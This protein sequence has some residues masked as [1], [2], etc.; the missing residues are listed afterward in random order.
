DGSLVRGFFANFVQQQ[1][2]VTGATVATSELAQSREI[3][4]VAR[5]FASLLPPHSRADSPLSTAAFHPDAVILQTTRREL[6]DLILWLSRRT[7]LDLWGPT[8]AYD[9]PFFVTAT[10]DYLNTAHA[11]WPLPDLTERASAVH[12][13]AR[14]FAQWLTLQPETNL[15]PD[16]PGVKSQIAIQLMSHPVGTERLG[17]PAEQFQGFAG[18]A[19]RLSTG[20]PENWSVRALS[21]EGNAGHVVPVN[22]NSSQLPSLE[23]EGIPAS[24]LQDSLTLAV[25]YR[26]FEFATT[27]TPANEGGIQLVVLPTT[28]RTTEIQVTQPFDDLG[29][30]AIVL[31]G[32]SSMKQPTVPKGGDAKID[33]ARR[34]LLEL[35]QQLSTLGAVDC[36]VRVYGHRVGYGELS[37]RV[38]VEPYYQGRGLDSTLDP[39][40]DIETV[41]TLGGFRATDQHILKQRLDHLVGWGQS[42]HFGAIVSALND[43][44]QPAGDGRQRAIVVVTDGGQFDISLE[45]IRI[46]DKVNLAELK[47]QLAEKPVP[48][49]FL[50]I[51]KQS[52]DDMAIIEQVAQLGG[53][54]VHTSEDVNGLVAELQSHD[55]QTYQV[56]GALGRDLDVVNPETASTA[57][58]G[59]SLILTPES[60]NAN[61]LVVAAGLAQEHLHIIGGERIELQISPDRANLFAPEYEREL[62]TPAPMRDGTGNVDVPTCFVHRPEAGTDSVTFPISWQRLDRR[63]VGWPAHVW[64]EVEPLGPA[65]AQASYIFYDIVPNKEAPI[66]L[67]RFHAPNWPTMATRALIRVWVS[68]APVEPDLQIAFSELEADTAGRI[69]ATVNRL[70]GI[71]LTI[72]SY[73]SSDGVAPYRIVVTEHHPN[74]GRTLPVKV[75]LETPSAV[76]ATRIT[77]HFDARHETITHTFDYPAYHAESVR[78]AGVLRILSRDSLAESG[79]TLGSGGHLVVPVPRPEPVISTRP[80][81][82]ENDASR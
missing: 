73:S 50:L 27:L 65:S 2:E 11:L 29:Q 71:E 21:S 28:D 40:A 23:L 16:A 39:T 52:P 82:N 76:V 68:P 24:D 72:V 69:Q 22:L 17:I 18:L 8:T 49:H 10:T 56:D 19:L 70:E 12:S 42:P 5:E 3:E 47:S 15:L 46:Q 59:T 36:S 7:T 41:Y 81:G 63:F 20:A 60:G 26:G 31:D 48:V 67:L 75:D 78:T 44:R 37:Q 57:T 77:R 1:E 74:A 51:G 34:A 4:C 13:V 54:S 55:R 64:V 62:A 9:T 43:L 80:S 14:Q 25:V 58:V 38:K 35:T 32:S 6:Q 33:V 66:P 79:W 53:G 45:E 30:V 61:D